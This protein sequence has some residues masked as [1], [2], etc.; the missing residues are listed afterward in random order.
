MMYCKHFLTE[1]NQLL[2]KTKSKAKLSQG[3]DKKFSGILDNNIVTR[4][5]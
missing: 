5:G 1:N 4:N 3:Q 2:E